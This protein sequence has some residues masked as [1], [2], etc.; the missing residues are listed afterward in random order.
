SAPPQLCTELRGFNARYRHKINDFEVYGYSKIVVSFV[1]RRLSSLPHSA[2]A[3]PS[4]GRRKRQSRVT[5]DNERNATVIRRVSANP[6][7]SGELR[8]TDKAHASFSDLQLN[9]DVVDALRAINVIK[10]TVIQMLSIPKILRGRNVIVSAETGSGKTLAYL[11]PLISSLRDDEVHRGFVSRIKRPRAV[12]LVPSRELA[13]QVL[14]VA[15]SLCHHARFRPVGL[16]GGFKKRLLNESLQTPCDV[17]VGT[18]DMVR[19]LQAKESIY[20]TDVSHVVIDEVDT[21][22]ADDFRPSILHI[23]SL[24]KVRDEKPPLPLCLDEG[25]QVTLVGSLLPSRVE[26]QIEETIPKLKKAKSKSLHTLMPH[27]EHWFVRVRPEDK[28]ER[29]LDI[30]RHRP[31]DVV[32]VF[33]NTVSSCDWVAAYLAENAIFPIKLHG[34]VSSLERSERLRLYREGRSKVL[35]CTDVASRG[36]DTKFVNHVILFDFCLNVADYVHRSG[37]VGRVGGLEGC[38]VTSLVCRKR[39]YALVQ[40]FKES[41]E[42]NEALSLTETTR[43]ARRTKRTSRVKSR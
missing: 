23:L 26:S 5:H 19:R 36:I 35:V 2:R 6:S 25:T 42:M 1:V 11:A 9:N 10:P 15:K 3:P 28:A 33:C 4:Q 7:I 20:M 16:F 41:A 17:V 34:S 24:L 21:M 39:E 29:L 8:S 12:I 22:W 14:A 18:P 37:R 32:M 27:V 31:R 40:N 13:I 38:R 43:Q 30:I